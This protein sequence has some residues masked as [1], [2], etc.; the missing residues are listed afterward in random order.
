MRSWDRRRHAHKDVPNSTKK[1]QIQGP[2]ERQGFMNSSFFLW[3]NLLKSDLSYFPFLMNSTLTPHPQ[4]SVWSQVWLSPNTRNPQLYPSNMDLTTCSF[5][6][7][8]WGR[9]LLFQVLGHLL[10]SPKNLCP[11][12]HASILHYCSGL[13][14]WLFTSSLSLQDYSFSGA[15]LK[16]AGPAQ[17]SAELPTPFLVQTTLSLLSEH[18]LNGPLFTS[19]ML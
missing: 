18:F 19:T 16:T 14:G 4:L 3:Q 8:T 10:S 15:I 2:L 9:Y 1:N 17:K 7:P 12:S 5:Y 11:Y 6:A 13:L